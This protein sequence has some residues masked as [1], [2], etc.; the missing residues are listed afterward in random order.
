L[1][2][3]SQPAIRHHQLSDAE[4]AFDRP[5]PPESLRGRKRLDDRAVLKVIAWKFGMPALRNIEP[6]TSIQFDF[7]RIVFGD[8]SFCRSV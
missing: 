6:S 2:G 7:V 3:G 1:S 8:H 5:L 4:R